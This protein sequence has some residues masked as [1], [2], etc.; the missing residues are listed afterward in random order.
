MKNKI[1]DGKTFA[2]N[3]GSAKVA[4]DFVRVG[5]SLHAVLMTDADPVSFIAT[6]AVEGVYDLSVVAGGAMAV[7]DIVYSTGAGV[8]SDTNTGTVAGYL[9]EAIGGAS[10]VTVNVLLAK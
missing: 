9:L 10:T 6:V 2:V 4:G 8:L 5:E 3:V 7:G 1:S